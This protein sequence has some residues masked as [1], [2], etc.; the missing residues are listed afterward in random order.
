MSANQD[1][2]IKDRDSRATVLILKLY[3]TGQV[4]KL[5]QET[6]GIEIEQASGRHSG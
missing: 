3:E 4:V 6:S 2:N 5:P 1:H